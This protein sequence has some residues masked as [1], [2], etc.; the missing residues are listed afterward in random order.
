MQIT[1]LAAI[2][3][4]Q[5]D[6]GGGYPKAFVNESVTPKEFVNL[7]RTLVF[8]DFPNSVDALMSLSTEKLVSKIFDG[9]IVEDGD[10]NSRFFVDILKHHSI[11]DWIR[12]FKK[13]L[14]VDTT[15]GDSN[16]E[17]I[18]PLDAADE[19]YVADGDDEE[20]TDEDFTED[21]DET[22]EDFSEEDDDEDDDDDDDDYTVDEDEEDE[23]TDE[24]ELVTKK[25]MSILVAKIETTRIEILS[26]LAI[27]S[28]I[29][30]L[31][32]VSTLAVVAHVISK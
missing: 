5:N 32:L 9:T 3:S 27:T 20:E 26:F 25:D 29:G 15:N 23:E 7:L 4:F 19:D 8:V 14:E 13:V 22:D 12:I 1:E 28:A 31:S 11:E 2:I 6:G 17:E 10:D 30:V 18:Q 21:G 16:D 24:D